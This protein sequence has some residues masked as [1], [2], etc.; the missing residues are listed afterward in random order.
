MCI[1]DRS[2]YTANSGTVEVL[3]DLQ[4]LCK[5]PLPLERE[6][7]GKLFS[8]REFQKLVRDTAEPVSYTHLDVYKRKW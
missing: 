4:Q 2:A 7:L 1:R 8:S 6:H 5:D 3:K